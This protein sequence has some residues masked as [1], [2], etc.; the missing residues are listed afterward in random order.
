ML[1]NLWPSVG[2]YA[3]FS[4][5]VFQQQVHAKNFRG[6]SVAYGFALS[7]FAFVGMLVGFAYLGVLGY[8][9]TW[10]LPVPILIAA[11]LISGLASGILSRSPERLAILG[12][13]GFIATPVCAWFMFSC[14]KI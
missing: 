13:I 12:A 3:L 4:F 1:E 9:T 7:T 6:G 10:W 11:A 8:S 14:I 2:W 5:F